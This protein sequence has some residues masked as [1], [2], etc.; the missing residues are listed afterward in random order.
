[1]SYGELAKQIGKP[2]ASRAIGMANGR[3]PIS[4]V[5]PCHRVIGK[6]GSL[7]G[8][9]GGLK[10][11]RWLIDFEKEHSQATMRDTDKIPC[12]SAAI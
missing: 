4:F 9:G 3:N 1:M 12:T 2:A 5:V 7:T 10:L 11:K 6:N 8:Y